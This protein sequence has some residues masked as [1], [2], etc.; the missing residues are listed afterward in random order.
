MIKA[1][2]FDFGGVIELYENEGALKSTAK[3]LGVPHDEFKNVYFQHNHLANVMNLDWYEMFRKVLSVF[4]VS[5]EKENEIIS[6]VR[7]HHSEGKINT[8]LIALFPKLRQLGLKIGI[9]SNATS[10]LREK[11]NL[12]GIAEL[13]DVIVISGEIGFQKPHKEAF[14]VLFEKLDLQPEEV[15]FIDDSSRS[16]EKASEIGYVSVLFK[17]NEQLVADLK[18]IGISL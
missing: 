8:G 5:T 1:I 6:M 2:V 4:N 15:I 13:V 12:N 7:A 9:L 10:E 11:L 17:N 3:L 16:L 18:N 14:Q